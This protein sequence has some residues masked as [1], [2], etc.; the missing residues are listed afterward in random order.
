LPVNRAEEKMAKGKIGLGVIGVNATNMGSTVS[1]LKDVPDLR[2]DLR[3]ICAARAEPLAALAQAWSVPFHSTDYRALVERP[4]LDVVAIYSPDHRHGEHCLAALAAG[5]HA[6]CTKPMVTSLEDARE[7]VQAVRKSGKK[8]LVGQTMRFD[9]QFLTLRQFFERG[10]LGTLRVAQAHYVH[11]MRPIYQFTPWRLEVPQ[12][13]MYG[14]IVHVA[15]I[16]RSF[17]GDVAEVHA[18]ANQGT[19][20][21]EYPFEDNYLLNLR[22][23]NGVIGQ[24]VGLYG[25]VHPPMPMMQVSLFGTGGSAISD[26]TDNEPGTLRLTLDSLPVHEPL[27]M[28]FP[29]EKDTSVYGHGQTVIRY[30]RHFQ[31]CLDEDREPS[32]GVLEGAK[33]VAVGAAAWDSVRSGGAV[34]V[35]DVEAG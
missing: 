7:L 29:P 2:Y 4:D 28:S 22:F 31:E 13:L 15:D 25:L 6:I 30:M 8:F 23:E 12:D 1:L 35:P 18:F 24:G 9:R 11:D 20:T 17:C 10:D 16:L 26:F 14:G 34:R 3:A 33:A 32:P 21:P 27:V 19:L 5:K